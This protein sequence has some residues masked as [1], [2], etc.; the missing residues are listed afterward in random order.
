M[1]DVDQWLA[2]ASHHLSIGPGSG[3]RDG[4]EGRIASE[5]SPRA[6][7]ARRETRRSMIGAAFAAVFGFIVAGTAGTVA[8]AR[9][10]PTWVAAPPAASPYSLLVGR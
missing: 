9:P 8:F 6:L 7:A 10:A 1:A 5:P 2:D 4:I 3:L